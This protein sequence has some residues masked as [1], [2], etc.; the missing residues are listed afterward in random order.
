VID[1]LSLTWKI[2]ILAILTLVLLTGVLLIFAGVQFRIS[3]ESFIVAPALNRVLSVS[4]ELAQDLGETPMAGRAELLERLS[5]EYDVDFYL[6]DGNGDS[7]TTTPARLPKEVV[8]EIATR[9]RNITARPGSTRPGGPVPRRAIFRSTSGKPTMYWVGV[10]IRWRTADTAT[11]MAAYL[12]VMS[13]SFIGNQFFFDPRPWIALTLALTIVFAIVW[14]PLIRSLTHAITQMTHAT[15]RIAE[16]QFDSRLQVHRRDEV[17]QLATSINRMTTQL[18]G[19]VKGQKRFLADIAHELCAPIAR[20]QMAL[21]ILEQ[22]ADDR[23]KEY[24]SDVKDDVQ[25]MSEL[26]DELLSF[27]KAGMQMGEADIVRVGVAD[28]VKRVLEREGT[29]GAKIQS[30]VTTEVAVMAN[31]DYLFRAISNLVRNA[32]RYAGNAGPISVSA[33]H[34]GPDTVISVADSGPGLPENALEEVFAPFFRLERS[35]GRDTGGS[36]LGLAIVKACV[37]ASKGS[38]RARNRRPSGLEVEIRLHTA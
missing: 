34:E 36:G 26:I 15:S 25:H 32:I 20:M 37:E 27:S 5:K 9:F 4:G 2:A 6:V 12:V 21:G 14:L 24:V 33:H 28:V 16:G 19:F 31:P 13:D 11:P 17:G 8:D 18:S 22:R 38:V 29:P 1:R 3:P 35:R 10:P 30:S 7:L 23:S